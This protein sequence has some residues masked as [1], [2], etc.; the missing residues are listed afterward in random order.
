MRSTERQSG[1]RAD[2]R[3]GNVRGAFEARG[4]VGRRVLLVDDVATSGSTAREC[5]RAL[6]EGGA[7]S[8]EVAVFARATRDDELAAATLVP[9]RRGHAIP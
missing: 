8:V 6:L 7:R 4:R 9:A 3:A 1:L 5:A 2:R